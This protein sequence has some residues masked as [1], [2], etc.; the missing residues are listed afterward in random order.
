MMIKN[1]CMKSRYSFFAALVVTTTVTTYGMQ[2]SPSLNDIGRL[3]THVLFNRPATARPAATTPQPAAAPF[4]FN[5]NWLTAPIE[6]HPKIAIA[7]TGVL[8]AYLVYRYH[9]YLKTERD[10]KRNY[11]LAEQKN[12]SK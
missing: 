12:I 5:L 8:A 4:A 7:T 2:R 1:I 6:K 11:Y 3:R 10:F 9:Q